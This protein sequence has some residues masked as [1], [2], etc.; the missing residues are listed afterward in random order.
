MTNGE[1]NIVTGAFGFSGR[2]ITRKLLEMGKRVKTI[3]GHP[4]RSEE[5]GDLVDAVHFNFDNPDELTRSLEGA[6][7][8][9]NTYWIRFDHGDMTFGRA[10]ENSKTLIK[11]AKDAGIQK[12]VHVSIT[13]PSKDSDL[14]YF[15]GKAEVEEAIHESGL[16]YAILRPAVLFGDQGI[17]INNIAWFLRRMPAFAIPGDGKYGVQPIHVD[18][19]AE[20]AVAAG[21]EEGSKTIDAVGP[22]QLTFEEMVLRIREA[23]GSRAS[24]IHVS[25]T[26][27]YYATRLFGYFVGDVILTRDEV[28]GLM[29]N[30]LVSDDP[31]TGR[32]KLSE[33][34][35]ENA[36]WLGNTY[37][38]EV[39]KH[40]T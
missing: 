9:Y 33:W 20:L 23:V 8:L 31:P 12:I 21:Q 34:L 40:F 15:S 13:N 3:T 39:K 17:L 28:K 7:T 30:L 6:T 14:P 2:H 19:L 38:S 25:P 35:D 24:I 29:D 11:A 10:V 27:S 18:D 16:S 22:E 36:E 26:M 4:R 5:F 32:I 1:L 37:F